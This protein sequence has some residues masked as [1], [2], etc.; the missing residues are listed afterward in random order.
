MR[1]DKVTV[2]R[3]RTHRPASVR[4]TGGNRILEN[5]RVAPRA[6][7]PPAAAIQAPSKNWLFATVSSLALAFA[8]S[9]WPVLVNLA[10]TW[11]KE[12]DYSHGFLVA[13]IALAILWFRRASFPG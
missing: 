11:S 4:H 3:K 9:Y 6:V 12:P 7:E 8:W 1:Q 13:P 5:T 2:S 10:E